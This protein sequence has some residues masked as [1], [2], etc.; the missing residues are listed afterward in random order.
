MVY[1]RSP[2]P[3]S[4]VR[5]LHL[6][7]MKESPQQKTPEIQYPE[8]AEEITAMRDVDQDMREKNLGDD[9]WDE[10]VDKRNTERMKE[11]IAEIGWPSASKVGKDASIAAWLLVQHADHD[12]NFQSHCLSL[13]QELPA[14]EVRSED[15]ALLTDRVRVNSEQPQI[16]GTQFRQVD[17]KHVPKDIEDVEHVNERRKALGLDTLE[18]NIE[19]MYKKYPIK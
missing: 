10:E 7:H 1:Q 11:I 2:K 14:D 8:I 15:I 6:P 16:Y 5:F 3:H 17:R 12:V 13:M 4:G 9:L 19:R 18:E